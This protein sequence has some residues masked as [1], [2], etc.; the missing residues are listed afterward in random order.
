MGRIKEWRDGVQNLDWA[1]ANHG[2]EGYLR[3][4]RISGDVRTKDWWVT[5]SPEMAPDVP[6]KVEELSKQP[7]HSRPGQ[8][9]KLIEHEITRIEREKWK[10]V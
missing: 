6:N 7:I 8:T 1:E 9:S 4:D 2:Q 10:L 3:F 5:L